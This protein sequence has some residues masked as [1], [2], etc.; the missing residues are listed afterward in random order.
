MLVFR[1]WPASPATRSMLPP[2]RSDRNLLRSNLFTSGRTGR[3][4]SFM[5][6]WF[7]LS[8]FRSSRSSRLAPNLGSFHLSSIAIHSNLFV[9][10][11]LDPCF[12]F[13]I[14]VLLQST[15]C[16]VHWWPVHL[17]VP[18]ESEV[19]HIHTSFA[20]PFPWEICDFGLAFKLGGFCN[21]PLYLVCGVIVC[22]FGSY[23][24]LVQSDRSIKLFW[25]NSSVWFYQ[26]GLVHFN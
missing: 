10:G 19:F 1:H 6:N 4:C 15:I 25:S 9:C 23:S 11:H 8:C 14:S 5:Q 3:A 26:T 20:K 18:L 17:S 16:S 13:Y 22:E 12:S 7:S 21:S 2:L 24:H